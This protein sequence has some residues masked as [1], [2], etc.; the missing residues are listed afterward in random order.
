MLSDNVLFEGGAGESV[1]RKL[2]HDCDVHTLLRLPTGLFYDHRYSALTGRQDSARRQ[3]LSLGMQR[4]A[5]TVN[6]NK[7]LLPGWLPNRGASA[8]HCHSSHTPI[9]YECCESSKYAVGLRI[10]SPSRK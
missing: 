6:Q 5:G 10:N 4:D 7:G 9:N 2:L 1:R 3:I 8:E